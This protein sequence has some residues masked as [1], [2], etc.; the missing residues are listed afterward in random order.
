MLPTLYYARALYP[1]THIFLSPSSQ[2]PA[3]VIAL[4]FHTLFVFIPITALLD[5]SSSIFFR[6]RL[7]TRKFPY[8]PI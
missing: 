4:A 3:C 1:S 2:T 8:L 5:V 6:T 7:C